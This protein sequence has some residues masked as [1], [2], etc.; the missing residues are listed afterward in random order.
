MMEADS[1]WLQK[2]IT[3]PDPIPEA[4]DESEAP[5]PVLAPET[6]GT[7]PSNTGKATPEDP[8]PLPPPPTSEKTAGGGEMDLTKIVLD[9]GSFLRA[10]VQ[11][12]SIRYPS[13]ASV[14]SSAFISAQEYDELRARYSQVK[15]EL[16]KLSDIQKDL[17]FA[18]F[19]LARSQEEMKLLRQSNHSLKQ[20]VEDYAQRVEKEHKARMSLE[21]KMSAEGVT[22]TEEVEF[23]KKTIDELREE[24]AKRLDDLAEQQEGE[25]QV[26][27]QSMR[28]ELAGAA[29]E[30][31]RLAAQV[32][33]AQKARELS[34]SKLTTTLADLERSRAEVGD[35]T[36]RIDALQR[37]CR[38]LEQ[39]HR[40]FVQQQER[41][42]AAYLEEQKALNEERVHQVTELKDAAIA[43]LQ[44]ELREW[45]EK[46][47]ATAEELAVAR[48]AVTELQEDMKQLAADRAKE[49]R[50]LAEEHRLALCER[51][52]QMD[53]AIREA[54]GSKTS[55]EEEAQSLRRQL[56]Q[57]SSE[58]ST[59]A[60]VLAQRERQLAKAEEELGRIKERCAVAEQENAQLASDAQLNAEAAE[61]AAERVGRL[62]KQNSDMEE[63]FSKDLRDAKERI[64]AL[65]TTLM[66]SKGELSALRKEQIKSADSGLAATRDLRAQVEALMEECTTLKAQAAERRRFEEMTHDYRQ[67][68]E[69]EKAKVATLEVEL[70]AAVDRCTAVEAKLEER[71]RRVISQALSRSPMQSLHANATA[72]SLSRHGKHRSVSSGQ[73][74][75][76]TG[77]GSVK[78]AR[79]EDARVFAISGFD[80]NNLLL[81]VKQ[82]PNVAIAECKSNMPVPSNLTHLITNGQLTIKLLTALV[83]GCWVL[84]ESYVVDSLREQKWLREEDYGFQHEEPPLLKRRIAVTATFMSCKHY[85]TATLLLKEGGAIVVDDPEQAE[86][87]LCTNAE[88]RNTKNGWNWEKMVEMIYPLKIQ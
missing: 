50:R 23:L 53:A 31:T 36:S 28:E 39:Q 41:Q 18:R 17:D 33:Q 62:M 30:M 46:T 27:L 52:L 49:M 54:R 2:S 84:P 45:K 64:R 10:S 51:Q 7:P 66:Q 71:S 68:Y 4:E 3:L 16:L 81:A 1:M 12:P 22:R 25:F 79:T 58:L 42:S 57:V 13:R 74:Y 8:L 85:S 77:G 88:A 11:R 76:T 21:S 15:R 38:A 6:A 70:T 40:D 20:E 37:E 65:E 55:I 29:E 32:T 75:T 78:R 80:G 67:R 87:L 86:I 5:A 63:E 73:S 60:G 35:C 69:A 61:E 9:T 26:R 14:S 83:R 56:A 48:H 44:E 24:N 59:V 19:E 72:A 47:K 43:E 34:E 82:L